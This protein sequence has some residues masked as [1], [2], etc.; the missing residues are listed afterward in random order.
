MNNTTQRTLSRTVK[1]AVFTLLALGSLEA[2]ASVRFR[3][4]YEPAANDY[5]VYMTP[6]S[7][8]KPDILLSAQITLVVPHGAESGTSFSLENISSEVQ[9]VNWIDN[10]RVNAPSENPASD[11]ISLA[12]Y[13]SGSK[14]PPFGW[15]A[16]QEK[17]I[18]T[19]TSN[20]GCVS[21]VKIIDNTD[22]FVHL[23]NSAGTNP[24]NDFMNIGWST[25]NAYVGNYGEG[26]TCD[27]ASISQP[28]LPTRTTA[29]VLSAQDEY[30]ESKITQLESLKNNASTTRQAQIDSLISRL[31]E[32]MTC[33]V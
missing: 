9:G 12:Y 23:P 32:R 6:D 25:S 26:V 29:C 8:P 20:Q 7:T 24:G 5:A 28:A 21:G 16:G 17:K 2:S 11:Y 3:V 19:F 22:P 33:K 10:S 13:F 4:G 18:L 1:A 15:T 31:Q 14:I 30:Y 27:S